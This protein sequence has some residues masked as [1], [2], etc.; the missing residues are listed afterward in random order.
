MAMAMPL[1]GERVAQIP[2][3]Q[4]RPPRYSFL[5][6]LRVESMILFGHAAHKKDIEDWQIVISE[7][8]IEIHAAIVR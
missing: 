7:R 3:L 1:A 4:G 6:Q 2:T 5:F 8:D